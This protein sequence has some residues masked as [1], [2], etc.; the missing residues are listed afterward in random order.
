MSLPQRSYGIAVLVAVLVEGVAAGRAELGL[1]GAGGVVD[2][3]VDDAGVVAR[4]VGG[5]LGLSLEHED[6]RVRVAA[7]ELAGGGE[8]EDARSDDDDVPGRSVH[9]WIAGSG[10]PP[11][12]W[13]KSKSQPSL[14]WVTWLGEQALV[15]AGGGELSG[16]PRRTARGELF[17]RDVQVEA[18]GR[19]VERDRV[20]GLDERE[21]AA[22]E[23]LGRDVE[24]AGA[25]GGAG[26][27]GVGDPDH[28][29]DAGL[30]QLLGDREHSPLRHARAAERARVAEDE[31]RVGG[32]VERRD[33]RR[34]RTC[35]GSPRRRPP[36][37]CGSGASRTRRSA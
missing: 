16:H 8:A 30:Q 18:A 2:A 10:T 23:G 15:A 37:P 17:F 26:H 29:S 14:A 35:P 11:A 13:R 36:G 34:A 3:R 31:D 6:S 22:G 33:R 28:V 19:D 21:R 25:V 27:P 12:P 20:A 4:L 32:D 1:Q 7:E 9:Q 24:H 5:D